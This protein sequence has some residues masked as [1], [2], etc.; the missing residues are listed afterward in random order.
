MAQHLLFTTDVG[1]SLNRFALIAE[2]K[3]GWSQAI[4][5]DRGYDRTLRNILIS[6][7]VG[8]DHTLSRTFNR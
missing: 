8:H 6:S 7:G 2:F 1:D 3:F 5:T 4:T